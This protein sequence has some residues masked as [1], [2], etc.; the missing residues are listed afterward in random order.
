MT[1]RVSTLRLSCNLIITFITNIL[2]GV[3]P[4]RLSLRHPIPLLSLLPSFFFG[5]F[6]CI[7]VGS[8]IS[9]FDRVSGS[10]AAIMSILC[11]LGHRAL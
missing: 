5:D 9:V 1:R 2:H 6:C 10:Y 8:C 11:A 3:P 4:I 7:V